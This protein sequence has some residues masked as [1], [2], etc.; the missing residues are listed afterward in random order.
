M[1]HVLD[2]WPLKESNYWSSSN[3]YPTHGSVQINEGRL[4]FS[5]IFFRS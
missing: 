4:G 3:L 2:E 1:I 5:S